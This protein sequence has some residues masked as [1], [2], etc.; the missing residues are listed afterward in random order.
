MTDFR[1]LAVALEPPIP[2]ANIERIAPILDALE[3]SFAPLRASIPQGAD[4]WTPDCLLEAASDDSTR[5]NSTK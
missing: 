2:A 3:T 5:S 1:R 4:V